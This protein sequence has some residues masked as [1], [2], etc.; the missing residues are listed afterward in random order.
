MVTALSSFCLKFI[1]LVP[2]CLS[3]FLSDSVM[4]DGGNSAP[5]DASSV[6]QVYRIPKTETL[7]DLTKCSAEEIEAKKRFWSEGLSRWRI[8]NVVAPMVDQR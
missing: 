8:K 7:G 3:R 4:V 2:H 5:N 6:D 1:E